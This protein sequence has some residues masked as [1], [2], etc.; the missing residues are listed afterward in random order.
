MA[1]RSSGTTAA[2]E[3]VTRASA[4][5]SQLEAFAEDL[6]ELLGK[7]QSKAAGWLGQRKAIADRLVD[8]RDTA[9]RLLAQL[10]IAETTAPRRGRPVRSAASSNGAAAGTARTVGR[11]RGRRRKMSAEARAR[12]SAAQKARW[13]K[14]KKTSKE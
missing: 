13:A 7:A 11:K 5:E 9:T 14:V 8:V 2:D 1:K 3:V 4:K 12:I 10:G 6:G